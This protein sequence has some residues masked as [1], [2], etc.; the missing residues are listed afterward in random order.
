MTGRP[1]WIVAGN[2][3]LNRRG[4]AMLADALDAA[5]KYAAVNGV[6]YQGRSAYSDVEW[7]RT[8]AGLVASG[9]TGPAG[10]ADGTAA[11]P[12]RLEM[13][14]SAPVPE[15][16]TVRQAAKIL[17]VTPRAVTKRIKAG[18]IPARRYGREW[19]MTEYDVRHA[20]R[21]ERP[22]G[23]ADAG[24]PAGDRERGDGVGPVPA[25]EA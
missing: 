9:R 17:R 15:L 5:M 22:R 1:S 23:A 3:V 24:Q 6:N 8:Q 20:A 21:N 7:L 11:V 25:V 18:D 2:L 10:S 19:L 14:S 4:A 16:L 12:F 13:P